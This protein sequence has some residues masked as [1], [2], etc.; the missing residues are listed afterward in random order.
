M[1][2]G[3]RGPGAYGLALPD[4]TGAARLLPAAEADWP[5]LTVRRRSGAAPVAVPGV[6]ET[7]ATLRLQGGG[8]VRVD[9]VGLTA[10]FTHPV[11]DDEALVHP[12]LAGAAA[13]VSRWLNR[14]AFH[15]GGFVVAS[16]AWAILGDKEHGKSTMLAWLT[17]QGVPLLTDDLLVVDDGRA[18]AGPRCV[19]LRGEAARQ[20][21]IGE[22][23]GVL[24]ARQ[25]F[26]VVTPPTAASVP[27]RGWILPTWGEDLR[28]VPVPPAR[29]LPTLLHHLALRV[30]PTNP[31]RLLDYAA[32]PFVE[33]RRPRR[34]DLLHAATELLLE[35][36]V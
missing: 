26:R 5:V 11:V 12:Y 24:G 4:L 32:L 36:A 17:Q 8:R 6:A 13:V 1:S 18:L 15:A 2:L 34:W 29:R 27:L 23:A 10:T 14:D 20:L 31:S 9:R 33:L 3:V 28:A 22:D 21:G 16:G 7:H 30:P 35:T 25:R 19:D